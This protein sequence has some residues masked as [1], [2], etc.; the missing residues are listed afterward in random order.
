MNPKLEPPHSEP[1]ATHLAFD[2]AEALISVMESMAQ[3]IAA[4]ENDV[5]EMQPVNPLNSSRLYNDI[6]AQIDVLKNELAE[7]KAAWL[8]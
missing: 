7:A 2:I 3:S 5:N 1:G 4:L 6:H 8:E